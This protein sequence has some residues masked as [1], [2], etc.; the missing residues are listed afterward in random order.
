MPFN[1]DTALCMERQIR[2]VDR[3]IKGVERMVRPYR[4]MMHQINHDLAYGMLASSGIGTI[5]QQ[6]DTSRFVSGMTRPVMEGLRPPAG[7]ATVADQA[8]RA[9]QNLA[10]QQRSLQTFAATTMISPTIRE[11]TRDAWRPVLMRGF[12][13]MN[14]ATR[15]N[16]YQTLNEIAPAIRKINASVAASVLRDVQPALQLLRSQEALQARFLIDQV[17]QSISA[18]MPTYSAWARV[19]ESLDNYRLQAVRTMP[20]RRPLPYQPRRNEPSTSPPGSFAVEQQTLLTAEPGD[21]QEL[22]GT[23]TVLQ[24]LENAV[25]RINNGPL[26]VRIVCIGIGSLVLEVTVRG[27][28]YFLFY[29]C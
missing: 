26:V 27:I 4:G 17:S 23:W 29:R 7:W 18:A 1:A 3:D 10:I 28:V 21:A 9:F 2:K 13:D 22:T 16:A 24:P 5:L 25:Q 8:T 14:L 11:V 6:M 12:Q 19:S 20:L 15:S